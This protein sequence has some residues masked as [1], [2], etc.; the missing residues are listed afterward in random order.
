MSDI[1]TLS[2]RVTTTVDG[3][4]VSMDVN[5]SNASLE[6]T[7]KGTQPAAGGIAVQNLND[8][9]RTQVVYYANGIAPSGTG[10]ATIVTLNKAVDGGVLTTGTTFKPT[11]GKKYRIQEI[12]FGTTGNATATTQDTT[13]EFKINPSGA[14]TTVAGYAAVARRHRTGAVAAAFMERKVQFPEGFEITGDGTLQFGVVFT[15]TYLA[16]APTIDVMIVGY[17]Y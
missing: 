3:A 13:F 16:N 14:V 7:A 17:E 4:V 9:G 15:S 5:A 10:T 11:T 12:I 8:S 2:K 6:T 1:R